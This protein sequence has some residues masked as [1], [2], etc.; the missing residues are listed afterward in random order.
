MFEAPKQVEK[1]SFPPTVLVIIVVVALVGGTVGWFLYQRGPQA[2]PEPE[3]TEHARSY[4][5]YLALSDDTGMDAAEDAL[6]QTLLEITGSIT[7][8]GDRVCANIQVNVVFRDPYNNEVDRQRATIVGPRTGPLRP[9]DT[10][11]F[12]LAFD[13]I[14]EAWNQAFPSLFISQISFAD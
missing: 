11:S 1:S 3:L 13:H 14:S 8:N 6:G 10:Q 4:L 2:P 9:G 12:R 7:N 5:P